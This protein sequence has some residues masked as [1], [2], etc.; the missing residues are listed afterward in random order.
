MTAPKDCKFEWPHEKL[1][2]TEGEPDHAKLKMWNRELL[3]NAILVCSDQ[4]PRGHAVLAVGFARCILVPGV[5]GPWVDPVHPGP[6]PVF[7][8]G[9]TAIA[10]NAGLGQCDHQLAQLHLFRA[11]VNSLKR[12]IIESMDDVCLAILRHG[13]THWMRRRPRLW[14]DRARQCCLREPKRF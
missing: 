8:Q 2:P 6:P 14:H 5:P 13:L 9:T 12:M 4:G 7:P 10:I 1:T 11:V 3:A